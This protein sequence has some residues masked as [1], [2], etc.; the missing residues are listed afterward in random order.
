VGV[1]G[2]EFGVFF[3]CGLNFGVLDLFFWTDAY[4]IDVYVGLKGGG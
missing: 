3:F 4:E 2:G 1:P